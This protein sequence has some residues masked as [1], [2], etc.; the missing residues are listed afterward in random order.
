MATDHNGADHPHPFVRIITINWNSGEL[1]TRCVQSLL[2]TEYP[3]DRF[4]IVVVDN[5]STDGSLD[6]IR[7]T[8]GGHRGSPVLRILENGL[9]LGFAEGCNRAMRDHDGISFV[10]LVNNDTEVE[11]DW[12]GHLVKGLNDNPDAGAASACLVARA[13]VC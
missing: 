3:K 7:T 12:L 11:V 9:N 1:T 5:G 4:E 8:F 6:S 2:D 13:V 10:A